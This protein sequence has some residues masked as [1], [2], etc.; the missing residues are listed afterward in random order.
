MYRCE[1][2]GAVYRHIDSYRC[3]MAMHA[4]KT[5]CHLC[6]RVFSRRAYLNQHLRAHHQ[7]EPPAERRRGPAAGRPSF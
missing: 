4:G 6:S 7:V 1:L 3:H 5:R 2:C